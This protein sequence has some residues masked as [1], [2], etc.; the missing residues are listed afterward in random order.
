MRKGDGWAGWTGPSTDG[1]RYEW[2]GQD[3]VAV[4]WGE[5]RG[6]K[7]ARIWRSVS[8]AVHILKVVLSGV[9]RKRKL[10]GTMAL[11]REGVRQG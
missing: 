9:V 2:E 1:M 11:G 3:Y 10:R 4:S 6:L 5:R 8:I 7:D